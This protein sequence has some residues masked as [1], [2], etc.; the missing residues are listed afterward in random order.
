MSSIDP[1]NEKLDR[2]FDQEITPKLASLASVLAKLFDEAAPAIPSDKRSAKIV[3][4]DGT[5][6]GMVPEDKIR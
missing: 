6:I 5:S 1:V 3:I 2:Y 4:E